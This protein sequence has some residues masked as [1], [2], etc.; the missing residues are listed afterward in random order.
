MVCG[1]EEWQEQLFPIA[2]FT[3]PVPVNGDF[4]RQPFHTRSPD[5]FHQTMRTSVW[6]ETLLTICG[7]LHGPTVKGMNEQTNEIKLRAP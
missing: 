5:V 1:A 3:F 6:Q 2:S 4:V 7:Q